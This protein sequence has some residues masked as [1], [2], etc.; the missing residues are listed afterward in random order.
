ME[1]AESYKILTI[2]TNTFIR[3]HIRTM[4]QYILIR[5]YIVTVTII[6]SIREIILIH[7]LNQNRKVYYK[8]W[9]NSACSR[10]N[11]RIIFLCCAVIGI[12]TVFSIALLF[13]TETQRL[14]GRAF[15]ECR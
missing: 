8:Y 11:R 2:L 13:T 5:L 14:R 15:L 9:Q 1:Y 6:I 12:L 10:M 4:A 7:I 3:L